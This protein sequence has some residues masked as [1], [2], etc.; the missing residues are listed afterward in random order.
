METFQ[1]VASYIIGPGFVPQILL[2]IVI[3]LVI[4]SIIMI[5][6]SVVQSFKKYNRQTAVVLADTYN[7]GVVIPQDR[8][9]P[10]YPLLYPSENERHGIEFS[11]S[12]HL[13]IDPETFVNSSAQA[14]SC[15]PPGSDESTPVGM[16]HIMH[17]GNRDA[18]PNMAPGVFLHGNKNTIRVYMNSQTKWNNYVDIPN[19]PVG[20]WFHMVISLKGQFMD[21]Y[22]NGNVIQRH[23]FTSVP[24]ANY[25]PIYV[26]QDLYFPASGPGP[27]NLDGFMVSGPMKGMISRLKYYSFGLNFS[28]IDSLY[29]EEPSKKIVSASFDG[30]KPPYF[31]DDWWVTKY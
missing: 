10:D 22:I 4:N 8:N 23:Q 3:F 11:Y 2:V 19:I 26:M 13:F 5:F 28:Q 6:E 16:K 21:V 15:S 9:E 30:W 14:Q 17:K 20:K 7:K 18:F 25:G 1:S 27:Q 31:H 12:F 24:K 29:R